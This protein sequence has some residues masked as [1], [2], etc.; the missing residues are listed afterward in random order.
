MKSYGLILFVGFVSFLGI[1]LEA[2]DHEIKETSV[3][4]DYLH[5]NYEDD[6]TLSSPKEMR[7]LI[8]KEYRDFKNLMLIKHG[9]RWGFN[10]QSLFQYSSH[11]KSNYQSAW[12]GWFLFEFAWIAYNRD[13]DLQGKLF[14][15]IDNRHT[16]LHQ[17][18]AF[19]RS[20]IGSL[21]ATD[22]A[23]LEWNTY[24]SVIIWEQSLKKDRLE[25]T[26][27]QFSAM[28][29]LDFFR[30]SEPST[31]F[32][33]TQLGA[34]VSMIPIGPPG[35]GMALKWYPVEDKK[36]YVIGLA[37]DLNAS[38]GKIDWSNLFT[39]KELF[40][41][42]E[43]GVNM[44]RTEQDFDH[45]HLTFWYGDQVSTRTFPTTSGWGFKINGSKQWG[46]VVAFGSMAYNTAIGGGFGY[47][48]TGYSVNGGLALIEP[49]GENGELAM[50]MSWA[51]PIDTDLRDQFGIETYWKK[52]WA[53]ELWVTP[54]IQ[55]IWNPSENP[56][57]NFLAL[58]Q[59][60][61]RLFF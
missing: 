6:T 27:G 36:W 7:T 4:E 2:A 61:A 18:P 35:L 41:G 42:A 51:R 22:G 8:P 24:P 46:R 31:S 11:S 54:G 43:I 55:C 52:R 17:A 53:S 37:N 3:Q 20:D 26:V 1:P 13:K 23:F 38:V 33:C 12:G 59:I 44:R 57:T 14:F 56:N 47:T 58:P 34:T 19:F 9:I 39:Y 48:N 40:I 25:L 5:S 49:N 21:W 30:F 15:T 60:K 50:G 10:Y 45:A 29:M 16:L 28:S 32:S